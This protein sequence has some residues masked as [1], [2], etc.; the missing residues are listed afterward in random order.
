MNPMAWLQ[1]RWFH[2][3]HGRNL[4]YNTCWEDPRLDR[5]ALALSS[6]DRVIVITSAGCNALDYLL[7]GP[8]EV[9][10]VDMNP[11]QNALLELKREAIRRL[12][13]EDFFEI[14]GRGRHPQFAWLYQGHLRQGLSAFARRYWDKHQRFFMGMG[15]RP[16][17]YFRG[18]SGFF[19]WVVNVYIDR[20][21]RVR[22]EI[23]AALEAQ[24]ISEQRD[25]YH[26]VLK[27]AFWNRFLRW[28]VGRDAT[29]ALLGV[30]REQR[31]Q[32]ERNYPGRVARFIEDSIEAVFCDLPL[33][34]NYF[35]RVYLTGEYSR[36]CCPE[37]LK[38][39]NFEALKGGLIDRLQIETGTLLE[40][41][42]RRE[43]PASRFVLLDH[44]D[45]LCSKAFPVLEEEWGAMLDQATA[46]ARFLWRSGGLKTDY[47]ERV[48]VRSQRR[49]AR[50]PELLSFRT[51]LAQLLH[52]HDRVHTYGSFYIAELNQESRTSLEAV[53]A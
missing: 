14:F 12:E 7:D 13:F 3:V 46:D 25:I 15:R 32:L 28:A 41:L 34:D 9:T 52:R 53:C 27:P 21:A 49:V 10:A 23:Q 18:S 19:A 11:R 1:N 22:P 47:L 24:S 44:M 29:L 39:H 31:L 8:A 40:H 5:E 4:V 17:F 30:P 20:V 42:G 35:W 48:V 26:S 36:E 45:W 50:L 33:R 2:A 16:S 51:D 37:Y 38:E 43:Q 6:E